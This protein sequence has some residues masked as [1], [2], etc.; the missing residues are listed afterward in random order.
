MF[1]YFD[2]TPNGSCIRPRDCVMRT[3]RLEVEL[4]SQLDLPRAAVCRRP[5]LS[6]CRSRDGQRREPI[7]RVIQQVTGVRPKLQVKPLGEVNLLREHRIDIEEPRS[8]KVVPSGIR[9]LP[10]RRSAELSALV[11]GEIVDVAAR[12]IVEVAYAWSNC[13]TTFSLR[14]APRTWSPRSTA[15]NT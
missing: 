3:R 5:D 13:Q 9:E 1:E 2:L 4:R 8:A 10:S 11:G 14:A 7:G 6:E 12:R 15:R